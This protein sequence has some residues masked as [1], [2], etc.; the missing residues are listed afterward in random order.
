M[1]ALQIPGVVVL[2]ESKL[3]TM[4]NGRRGA[5]L[6]PLVADYSER[7]PGV[8][9]SALWGVGQLR[10]QGW[11]EGC[12]KRRAK[13]NPARLAEALRVQREIT[14]TVCTDRRAISPREPQIPKRQIAPLEM[15]RWR[16]PQIRARCRIA[17]FWL[18]RCPLMAHDHRGTE[19]TPVV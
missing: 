10:W 19:P 4:M 15:A 3:R 7:M 1:S 5:A 9:V 2:E 18:S 12:F 13:S 8:R 6:A 16:R 11:K 14:L 17:L